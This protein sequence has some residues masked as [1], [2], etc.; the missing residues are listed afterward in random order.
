MLLKY[1]LSTF[2]ENVSQIQK[3]SAIFLHISDGKKH[4]DL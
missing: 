4:F 1:D 2:G 3:I